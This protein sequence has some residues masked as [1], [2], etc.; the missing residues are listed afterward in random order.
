VLQRREWQAVPLLEP[1]FPN[2]HRCLD[3]IVEAGLLDLVDGDVSLSACIRTLLT[4]GHT[5]GH[6]C[7]LLDSAGEQA[8]IIGDL[9]H[10]PMQLNHPEWQLPGEWDPPAGARERAALVDRVEQEGL[11]LC[12]GHFPYPSIGKV[13][14]AGRRRQ[15]QPLAKDEPTGS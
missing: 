12:A 11:T 9:M 10:S 7:V 3:P 2:L 4:P 5:P 14:R 6:Q 1:G 15:W 8:V 13:L